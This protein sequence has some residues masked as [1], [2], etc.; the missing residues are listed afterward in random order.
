MYTFRFD[1][2]TAEPVLA[3]DQYIAELNQTFGNGHPVHALVCHI[4]C[5][6]YA[7]RAKDFLVELSQAGVI[8]LPYSGD[9]RATKENVPCY[10]WEEHET[11]LECVEALLRKENKHAKL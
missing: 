2:N 3:A 4:R 5:R 7:A 1:H 8:N 6:Q 10:A 11:L 9:G